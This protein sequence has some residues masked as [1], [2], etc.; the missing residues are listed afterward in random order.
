VVTAAPEGIEK[1]KKK[2]FDVTP[3]N[4][5]LS[6]LHK[7]HAK[8]QRRCIGCHSAEDGSGPINPRT[9]CFRCHDSEKAKGYK[10]GT[11]CFECHEVEHIG[12]TDL[13]PLANI[14]EDTIKSASAPFGNAI[15][16]IAKG[17]FLALIIFIPLGFILGAHSIIRNF[18]ARRN[19]EKDFIP[20]ANPDNY[21]VLIDP[22]TC[23]AISACAYACPYN[24]IELEGT[25]K[26][27]V[28]K[29]IGACHGCRAC[30][31]V[32]TP[33]A[34]IVV[35]QGE[36]L[37]SKDF[38][39]L[40]PYYQVP[41]VPG[42][43]LI[44]Q[45][46]EFKGLMKNASNM[47]VRVLKYITETEEGGRVKPG[48]SKAKGYDYDV[49]I[50]GA[51][52]GG[53]SAAVTASQMGLSY[54]ICEKSA[55]VAN[56]HRNMPKG[57]QLQP[58]P[59]LLGGIGPA[60]PTKYNTPERP[61]EKVIEDFERVLEQ[62]N[63]EVAFKQE[64]KG[65][66]QEGAGFKIT[67]TSSEFTALKVIIAIGNNGNPRKPNCPGEDLEKVHYRL[68]D[69]DEYDGKKIVILG[70]GNSAVEAAF[71]LADSNGG[72]NE[73]TLSY[74]KGMEKMRISGMNKEKLKEYAD[75]GKLKLMLPTS[76]K[77][78]KEGTIILTDGGTKE[79]VEIPNDVTFVFFGSLAPRKWLEKIGVKYASKPANWN[80][81]ATDD[82]SFLSA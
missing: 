72:S 27:A 10:S 49:F 34:I 80:P 21:Y 36:G 68:S 13:N 37:P 70:G 19:A 75:A 61:K 69:P 82:L 31:K 47:A 67:T 81:G 26:Q 77:E 50:A 46:T 32:C 51:G 54:K 4:I 8:I 64:V 59:P 2:A 15:P 79:D 53:V 38:P 60:V 24:V 5:S 41:E 25:P 18:N 16:P 42:L 12:S 74:R 78:I 22:E 76:P 55:G 1:A 43:F 48:D 17:F 73:V 65:I 44:G 40:D 23:V 28:A 35:K 29:R 45:V 62:N 20:P 3:K 57:K 39:D 30:E 56:T 66:T 71:A 52:P 14:D 63:V 6:K 7:A 33:N 11:E 9:A 58:N